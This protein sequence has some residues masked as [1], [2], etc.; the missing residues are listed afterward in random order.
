MASGGGGG[1]GLFKVSMKYSTQLFIGSASDVNTLP[2]FA[3]DGL[4]YPTDSDNFRMMS[5]RVLILFLPAAFSTS[6]AILS[7]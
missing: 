6:L 7:K 5:Y 4:I 3:F 2:S 1:G